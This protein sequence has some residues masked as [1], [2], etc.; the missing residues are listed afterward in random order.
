MNT[1]TKAA[2]AQTLNHRIGLTLRESKLMVEAFFEEIVTTLE[3][4]EEV[5]LC[6]FG[7]FSLRNKEER[8]GRNLVTGEFAVVCARRIV[9]FHP[10]RSLKQAI[11]KRPATPS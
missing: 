6:G 10:S 8:P 1:V 9:V 7:I 4:G 3:E 11:T 5:K 2:L